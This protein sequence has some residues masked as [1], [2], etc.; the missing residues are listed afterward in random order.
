MIQS[1]QHSYCCE[2]A[3][4]VFPEFICQTTNWMNFSPCQGMRYALLPRRWVLQQKR[5]TR[6]KNLRT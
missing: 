6:F 3:Q 2:L 5:Q 1:G 4:L